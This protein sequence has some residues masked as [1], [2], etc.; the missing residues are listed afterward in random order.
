MFLPAFFILPSPPP[1]ESDQDY[2][3]KKHFL[4]NVGGRL[5]ELSCVHCYI[6]LLLLLTCFAQLNSN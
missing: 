4:L 3:F 2:G 5:P 6:V 1:R